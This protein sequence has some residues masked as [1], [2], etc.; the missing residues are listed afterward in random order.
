MEGKIVELQGQNAS[1]T[2]GSVRHSHIL[3]L[4]HRGSKMAVE[5]E[6]ATCSKSAR[7][8]KSQSEGRSWWEGWKEPGVVTG[9]ER[10]GA[11]WQ[12]VINHNGGNTRSS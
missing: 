2:A 7:S 12:L 4:H 10:K 8:Q 9:V 1:R 6:I 11:G 5:S 3:V